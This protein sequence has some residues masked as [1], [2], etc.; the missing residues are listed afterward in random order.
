MERGIKGERYK[1]VMV[2]GTN[3]SSYISNPFGEDPK[4]QTQK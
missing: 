4:I 1:T 2:F 3:A